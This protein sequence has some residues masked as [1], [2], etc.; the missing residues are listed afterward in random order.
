MKLWDDEKKKFVQVPVEYNEEKQKNV[1]TNPKA[2][3]KVFE[4]LTN[5]HDNVKLEDNSPKQ[6]TDEEREKVE[7]I[8]EILSGKDFSNAKN[9]IDK[10]S[11]STRTT[12]DVSESSFDESNDDLDD[13]FSDE[14]DN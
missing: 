4:F 12:E 14:D 13:F 8:I 10:T 11:K 3:K 5:R 2:Q 7:R 6:W 1:I 9:K